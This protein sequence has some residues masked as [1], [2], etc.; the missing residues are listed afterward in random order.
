MRRRFRLVQLP[1]CEVRNTRFDSP[2]RAKVP[3]FVTTETIVTDTNTYAL[4][5]RIENRVR[6]TGLGNHNG[7]LD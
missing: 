1:G 5:K 3:G 4:A 6:S 2:L 7:L